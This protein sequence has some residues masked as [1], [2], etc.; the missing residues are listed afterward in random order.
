MGSIYRRRYKTKS[1]EIKESPTWW[2]KYYRDGRPLRESSGSSREGD[3]KRLLKLREGDIVRG[4]PITPRVGRIKFTELAKAVVSDYRVNGKRSLRD[5]E[6]RLRLHVGPYFGARRA[7]SITTADINR[8]LA[9]R[10]EQGAANA[11]INRETAIVKRAFTLG[12]Q[13]GTVIHAPHIPRLKESRPR[14]GFFERDRFESLRRHLSP[15]LRRVVTFSYLTGWRVPSEVLTLQWRQ[16]DFKAG[17]V[18]LD[19]GTTKNDEG[20]V[21]YLRGELLAVLEEQRAFTD[22]TQRE[23]DVIIP[24]VWHRPSGRRIVGFRKAWSTACRKAGVP[25]AIL[26]HFRRTAV[27]NL[28]RA[29]IPESVAMK[30]TGH[31]TRSVFERYNVTATSDLQDAAEMLDRYHIADGHESGHNGGQRQANRRVESF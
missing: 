28:V 13:A 8:Y 5:L 30:L 24:W 19:P 26:H 23:L 6:M 15:T 17:T 3:A 11:S 22:Q 20:R 12:R 1:G 31:K 18:T 21:F 9:L 25:G 14:A 10:Q 4:V 29:G 27:R 16:V 2:L 7:A